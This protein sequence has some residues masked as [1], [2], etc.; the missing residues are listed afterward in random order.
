MVKFNA[1]KKDTKLIMQI[2]KRAVELFK[3]NKRQVDFIDL[4]MDITACHLNGRPL[5][6]QAMLIADEFNFM[7]DI[8]GIRNNINRETGKIENCFLPRFSK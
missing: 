6:L 2:T 3:A 4:N 7:H 5:K 1:T 8:L